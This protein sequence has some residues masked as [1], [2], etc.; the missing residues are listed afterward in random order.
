MN[1][2]IIAVLLCLLFVVSMPLAV[3]ANAPPS[4][5]YDS[6]DLPGWVVLVVLLM[7]LGPAM[8]TVFLE[9]LVSVFCGLSK[10]YGK[11]IVLTNV[12]TQGMMWY[13]YFACANTT[14]TA[15]GRLFARNYILWITIVEAVILAGEYLVYRWKMQD[16]SRKKQLVYALTANAVSL[17]AGLIYNAWIT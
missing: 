2:R 11:L 15:A 17:C 4:A 9:W 1:R 13:L 14:A 7:I 16:V 12:I 6:S 10:K 5:E 8:M 3:S